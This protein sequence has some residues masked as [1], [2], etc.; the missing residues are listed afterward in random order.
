MKYLV[1]PTSAFEIVHRNSSNVSE[2]TIKLGLVK[3]VITIKNSTYVSGVYDLST[4]KKN[5]GIPY[6]EINEKQSTITDDWLAISSNSKN[7]LTLNLKTK[8][9]QL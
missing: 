2:L 7:Q 1:A 8:L 3:P 9:K 5:P 4:N 6:C